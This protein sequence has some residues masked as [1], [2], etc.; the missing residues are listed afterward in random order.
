MIDYLPI[1]IFC[2]V[3]PLILVVSTYNR[4]IK[5]LNMIEEGWS[6]IDVALKRRANLI[7]KLVSAVSGYSE[8]ES[9]TLKNV[10]AQRLE[11]NNRD[12]RVKEETE[13]SRSLGNLL[14]VAENYP[15]LKASDNFLELQ[16][17]LNQVEAEVASSRNTFN[18]RIRML[19][20]LV[21]QFPSNIIANIFNFKRDEY[22]QLELATEREVPETPWDKKD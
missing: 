14:A 7:P 19:N 9:E 16:K 22:F 3:I 13:V 10:T 17:A 2:V 15:E 11:S 8:H 5:Y 12:E 6:I 21:Q 18:Q 1:I 20:T 4:F